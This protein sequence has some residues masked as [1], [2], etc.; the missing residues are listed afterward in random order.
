M[1][2]KTRRSE[3]AEAL[4]GVQRRIRN[5]ATSTGRSADDVVLVVVTKTWPVSDIRNLYELGVR[6]FAENRH[7]DAGV[8]A[9]ELV[10]LSLRWHFV[11]QIQSNKA[12]RI[13]VYAE[14]V[15]S[16][17][18]VRVAQRLNAGAHHHDRLIKCLVQVS[19]VADDALPQRNRGGV[20]RGQLET[21]AQAI[22]S[23]GALQLAGVM[24]VAPRGEDAGAAYARLLQASGQ[25]KAISPRARLVSA[26]MSAD[27]EVAIRAGATHVR[28][29]SAV[30]GERPALR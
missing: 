26:G 16:V 27:F 19:L 17:D 28:V 5:A 6:D 9:A 30:L 13:A 25:V 8:K 29:G 14:L 22:D 2:S 23:A 18:S 20:A 4:D 12:N 3:L 11:G 10:D 7:Q 24:G 1:S 15:H 21:V